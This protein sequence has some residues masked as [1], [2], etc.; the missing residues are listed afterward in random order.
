MR[1]NLRAA[2]FG[3]K[4]LPVAQ[5]FTVRILM[6]TG[7]RAASVMSSFRIPC[8]NFRIKTLPVAQSVHHPRSSPALTPL[9]FAGIFTE[10][11]L[12][13]ASLME[14]CTYVE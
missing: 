2:D 14:P 3:T 10:A 12:M 7:G 13:P 1:N 9:I 6:S 8:G 5:V 4:T 11:Q